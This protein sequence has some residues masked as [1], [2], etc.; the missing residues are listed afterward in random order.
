MLVKVTNLTLKSANINKKF[1][2]LKYLKLS[3]SISMCV[4]CSLGIVFLQKDTVL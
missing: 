3:M 2:T 4:Y 1:E